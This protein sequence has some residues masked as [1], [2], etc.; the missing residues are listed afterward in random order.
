MKV[1]SV[2][3]DQNV[4]VLHTITL[5]NS[6][7]IPDQLMHS[8]PISKRRPSQVFIPTRTMRRTSRL[9]SVN[10]EDDTFLQIQKMA[11]I[12]EMNKPMTMIKLMKNDE[13]I[14]ESEIE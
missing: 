14:N 4:T 7:Q 10:P 8:T 6:I 9:F 3:I 5:N 2:N 1:I 11:S 12:S 13:T